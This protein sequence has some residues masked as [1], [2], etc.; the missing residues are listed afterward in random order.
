MKKVTIDASSILPIP[1]KRTNGITRTTFELISTLS[2]ME[3]PFELQLFS[4]RLRGERLDKYHFGL[5]SYHLPLPR[6]KSVEA[7]TKN[8]PII[9]TICHSDLYHIPHN[10]G[11]YYR[12]DKVIVTIHD[13]LFFSYPEEH[14]GTKSLVESIP[15]FAKDCRGIITCSEHSKKDIVKY[16]EVDPDKVFVIYWGIDHTLF[17]PADDLLSVRKRVSDK[18]D[19]NQPFFLS[20]SCDIGRKNTPKLVDEYLKLVS[21]NPINDLVLVWKN[22]PE[23]VCNKIEK[24]SYDHRIHIIKSVSDE[25]L[26]DLYSISTALVFPSLYEGFGLPVLEAMACGTAVI[27]TPFSSLSEVGG[28]AA[29]YIDPNEENTI[30]DAFV[31]FE[32][33]NINRDDLIKKGLKHVKQFTWE[34]CAQ[35]TID[36]YLKLLDE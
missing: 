6:W 20:V 23:E 32:N 26:R 33:G 9:E 12:V 14:L 27:T 8:L 25:D 16:L 3:L 35:K 36:V 1:G 11:P 15:P 28:D 13:T 29:Y 19:L 10:Y 5:P 31:A 2:S 30:Y 24:S 21:E 7:L 17:S 18:L 22:P 34:K 4:Q